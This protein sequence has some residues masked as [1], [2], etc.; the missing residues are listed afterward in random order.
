MSGVTYKKEFRKQKDL[1]GKRAGGKPGAPDKRRE[2]TP[3][4]K[5]GKNLLK[6]LA[7]Y[8]EI[9]DDRKK[10]M[11]NEVLGLEQLDHMSMRVLAAVLAYLETRIFNL[12]NFP[13][14]VDPYVKKLLPTQDE[15]LKSNITESDE[16]LS[17]KFKAEIYQYLTRLALYRQDTRE[18]LGDRD[19][20]VLEDL[21]ADDP[22][23]MFD[24]EED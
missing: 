15:R 22:H 3:R 7:L 24:Y 4:Q 13:E 21:E 2:L 8:P 19:T 14:G 5:A 17:L 10:A 12:E 18:A 1:R 6:E 16:I 23:D 9:Q 20:A 11:R